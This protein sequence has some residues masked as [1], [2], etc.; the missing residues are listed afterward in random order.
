MVFSNTTKKNYD[1]LENF[2]GNPVHVFI[3]RDDLWNL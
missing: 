3:N 2:H 1:L